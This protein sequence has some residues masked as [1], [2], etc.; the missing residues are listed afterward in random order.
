MGIF[1]RCS[2][3]LDRRFN[4][5]DGAEILSATGVPLSSPEIL[6]QPAIGRQMPV[7]Y[8]SKELHYQVCGFGYQYV[9]HGDKFDS[10]VH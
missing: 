6:V 1:C 3:L 10:Y 5:L 9:L 8:G 2:I 7:H 4:S